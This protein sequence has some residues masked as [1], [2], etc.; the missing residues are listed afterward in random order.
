M[1]VEDRLEGL[2]REALD[3]DSNPTLEVNRINYGHQ[4]ILTDNLC[5]YYSLAV[6]GYIVEQFSQGSD[7][8]KF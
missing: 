1:S 4:N 3:M 6:I 2:L 7:L 5:G 8:L